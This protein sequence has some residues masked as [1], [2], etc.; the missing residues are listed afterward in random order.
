MHEGPE[1]RL[2]RRIAPTSRL[3]G[4]MP[5]LGDFRLLD[6]SPAG[7][8]IEHLIL[9]R[10]GSSCTLRL[11]ASSRSL[12]LIA[13]VVW[14]SVVGREP[15]TGKRRALRYQSGLRFIALS[16]AQERELGHLLER[17]PLQAG[18]A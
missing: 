4:Q 5:A 1:R 14:S 13:Q 18:S 7:A 10:P 16:P 9:L 6:L 2:V 15:R 12:A 17:L 3:T 8:R 11:W